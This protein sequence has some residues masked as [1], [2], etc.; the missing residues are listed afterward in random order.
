MVT[1]EHIQ[2][3]LQKE[4]LTVSDFN[5]IE[6]YCKKTNTN[7]SYYVRNL[8]ECVQPGAI[9]RRISIQ[10]WDKLLAALSKSL[11]ECS[12]PFILHLME[13]TNLASVRLRKEDIDKW[14]GLLLRYSVIQSFT[15]LT[16]Q[17]F[18]N[19]LIDWTN[20]LTTARLDGS[21]IY[22]VIAKLSPKLCCSAQP[23]RIG[24]RFRHFVFID[25]MLLDSCI[26]HNVPTIIVDGHP[27]FTLKS[28]IRES[29][30]RGHVYSDLQSVL[31]HPEYV[32]AIQN[33]LGKLLNQGAIA[34]TLL[35]SAF[36]H[37]CLKNAFHQSASQKIQSITS[38]DLRRAS[39]NS[40]RL[41][42]PSFKAIVRMESSLEESLRKMDIAGRLQ[43][44]LQAGVI[45]EL[46]WKAFDD[47]IEE[48]GLSFSRN[49]WYH[50]CF[51]FSVC[52]FFS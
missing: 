49:L 17:D 43:T 5:N 21:N 9:T 38:T 27:V 4:K 42:G 22:E 46:G 40:E 12:E 29:E 1:I 19:R 30:K 18:G 51:F 13:L 35:Q 34:D 33:E 26:S 24:Y 36:E 23:I 20:Q 6:R 48:F 39:A 7:I 14:T 11:E 8:F 47:A 28:W 52:Q 50:H 45:D 15:R 41:R 16:S 32:H 44:A 31:E 25:A 10:V 37:A 2:E 3:L